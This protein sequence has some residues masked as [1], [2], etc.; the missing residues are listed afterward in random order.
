MIHVLRYIM[1]FLPSFN[2]I[3]SMDIK[4]IR[5]RQTF[6]FHSFLMQSHTSRIRIMFTLEPYM[7]YYQE[8][9]STRRSTNINTIIRLFHTL[10]LILH[11]VFYER[12]HKVKLYKESIRNIIQMNIIA[13]NTKHLSKMQTVFL[14]KFAVEILCLHYSMGCRAN[15]ETMETPTNVAIPDNKESTYTSN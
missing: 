5:I 3:T 11:F 6:A 12:P 7:R 15:S 14:F 1:E 13:Q 4:Q 8:I 2:A 10:K 9:A